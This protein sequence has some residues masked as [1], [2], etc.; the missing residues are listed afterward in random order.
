M[1]FTDEISA[2]NTKEDF[3]KFLSLMRD[4]LRINPAGWENTDLP[5]FLEAMQ[6]WIADLE[7]YY[8][9]I[10]APTPE[11]INWRIFVDILSGAGT[12]E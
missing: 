9:H 7:G 8:S 12:Y 4:D 1:H 5:S 2:V 10:G 11:N 3:L 6:A